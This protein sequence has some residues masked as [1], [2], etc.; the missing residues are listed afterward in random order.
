ML[1]PMCEILTQVGYR[2]SLPLVQ[3]R[4]RLERAAT[5]YSPR[6]VW[7]CL[8]YLITIFRVNHLPYLQSLATDKRWL[9]VTFGLTP[10]IM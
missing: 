1:P 2:T 7:H 6:T 5:R 4:A 9:E 8:R 10:K 3:R